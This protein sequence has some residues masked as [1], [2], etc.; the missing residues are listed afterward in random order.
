MLEPSRQVADGPGELRLDAVAPTARRRGV[1][2]L[3]E[4]EQATGPHRAEPSAHRIGVTRIDQQ[5]VRHEEPAVGHPRIHA[6][7]ALPAHACQVGAVE[8]LEDQAEAILQLSLPLLQHR[9]RR[10]DD[11][12]LRL[13]A[14]QQLTGDEPRLDGLAEPGVVCNKQV[15]PRQPQRLAERLH[16]VGVDPD[17][18]P[19]G[20]L[21]EIGV[22][23]GHAVPAQRVQERRELARIVETPFGEVRPTL[24]FQDAAV[25]LVV[26]EDPQRL[27]LR[28]V[29]GAGE[30]HEGGSAWNL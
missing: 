7:A 14:Q 16:L 20:R 17:A 26:P 4:Y 29:V 15:D 6:E 19:K 25:D 5:V 12:R 2:R 22:R 13:P 27:S 24:F 21:E 11:D 9:R 10:R 30:R 3:V 8:N 18:G 1:V 23:G 28:V